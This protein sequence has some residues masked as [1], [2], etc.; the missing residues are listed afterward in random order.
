M[1]LICYVHE[2]GEIPFLEYMT[3]YESLKNDSEKQ[4]EQKVKRILHIKDVLI[5]L[6]K[7]QGSYDITMAKQYKKRDFGILEIKE[8][9]SLLRVGFYT[10]TG[11]EIVLLGVHDKPN[12]NVNKIQEALDIFEACKDDYLENRNSVPVPF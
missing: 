5:Y 10:I 3:K 7:H 2:N 11:Q 4:I 9:K 12:K 8:G 6:Y 1:R